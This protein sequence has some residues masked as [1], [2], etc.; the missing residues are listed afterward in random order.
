MTGKSEAERTEIVHRAIRVTVASSIGFYVFLYALPRPQPE[1]ALYAL[2]AP[3]ALGALSPIP[4]SGR[5]RSVAMLKALPV[6]LLLVTLGTLL[7]VHTWAAV[8]GMLVVGFC[9]AFSA[10]AGPL[11]A[12]AAP[13]LQLFY[14]LACFPPYAPDT[15]V[16][17]LAG[18]AV[19]VLLLAA[20]E[21]VMLPAPAP[22]GYRTRLA[23]ALDIAAAAAANPTAIPPERL[24][25]TGQELRFSKLPPAERPAGPGRRDR[26]L[27]QGSN[28]VRR[29][30]DQLARYGETNRESNRAPASDRVPDSDATAPVQETRQSPGAR[31]LA[32]TSCDTL[33]ERVSRLCTETA[34]ALREGR[35]P[36]LT[37]TLADAMT[38]FQS[39]RI[40]Q[41]IGPPGGVPS[42]PLLRRQALVL[43]VAETA[44][45]VETS[46]QVGLVGRMTE[47]IPPQEL[48]WYADMSTS[49]LWAKRLLGNMTLHSVMFQNAVRIALGL[50]AARLV[51]GSLDLAHGFWVLLAVLT[52][53]RTTAGET[54]WTVRQ[55]LLGNLVGAVAAGALLVGFGQHS[56]AYAIVFVPGMLA[57][58]ALGPMLGIAWSQALFTLVVACVFAQMAPASWQ[59]AEE[60][61][62]DIVT[63]SMIGLLCGLIAWPAGARREVRRTMAELLRAYRPL[64]TGTVEVLLAVPPGAKPPPSTLPALH[65]LRLAETAYAQFRSEPP[66][67]SGPYADWHGVLVATEHLLLGALWLPKIDLPVVPVPYE[68][69]S[70]A[71]DSAARLGET[72]DHIAELAADDNACHRT[73]DT[74]RV[75][76]PTDDRPLPMLIDLEVWLNS[77]LAQLSRVEPTVE[78]SMR[79]RRGRGDEGRTTV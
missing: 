51:A 43:G 44:R 60:R 77:L 74:T 71:R 34:A 16:L 5:Q 63:G 50:G 53:G 26:A 13:G 3:I 11:P 61:I 19:G 31:E 76:V 17:R 45:I 14:I 67:S 27:A 33:L 70:W 20:F 48:F 42:V 72:S 2:F 37:G 54:W 46:I 73:M 56:V 9:L 36:A 49:R 69:A 62:I 22:P 10:V 30:L 57:A 79:P 64:V 1:L 41:A 38:D 21:V 23:D 28:A 39:L 25:A 6:G 58:F 4:G 32:R 65:R 35:P 52:L 75:P 12:G 15:L 40:R 7:A 68:A 55:A 59:L 47:P 66:L 24:R 18:L 8:L 78:A 29:L